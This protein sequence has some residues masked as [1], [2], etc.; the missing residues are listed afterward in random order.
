MG[1]NIQ[2][3]ADFIISEIRK[4][5]SNADIKIDNNFVSVSISADDIKKMLINE[6]K[7]SRYITMINMLD[8]ELNNN[9]AIFKI[10]L[11]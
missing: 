3:I 7:D 2:S 1:V 4:Y 9:K 5:F 8:I 11:M 6:I 10:R